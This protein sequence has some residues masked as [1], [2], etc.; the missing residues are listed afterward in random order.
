MGEGDCKIKPKAVSK[1]ALADLSAQAQEQNSL[2]Q[3][4]NQKIRQT[5]QYSVLVTNSTLFTP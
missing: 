2:Q 5:T 1:E 3:L 4:L